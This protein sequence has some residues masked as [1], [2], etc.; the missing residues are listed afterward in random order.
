MAGT[1]IL[2]FHDEYY[3]LSNFAP[4]PFKFFG[5]EYDTNEHFYQSAKAVYYDD[6]ESVRLMATPG[7]AKKRGRYIVCRPDWEE[8]K[9]SVMALGLSLKFAPGTDLADRLVATGTAYLEE[10]NT[11]GD[12]YWGVYNGSGS[13]ML[14]RLLMVQRARLVARTTL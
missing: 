10:T 6:A 1:D 9:D 3:W 7:G 8:V 12:R 13:N 2:G 4:S 11:W 14:G 5:V